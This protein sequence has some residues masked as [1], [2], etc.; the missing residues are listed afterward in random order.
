MDLPLL[1]CHENPSP[2]M[3]FFLS[4]RFL[5]HLFPKFV[6]PLRGRA[7]DGSENVF[8]LGEWRLRSLLLSFQNRF[9]LLAVLSLAFDRA[10]TN[11]VRTCARLWI[12]DLSLCD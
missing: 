6:K 8:S 9:V 3:S 12:I 4:C 7:C 10:V 11:V 1:V 5:K 2:T